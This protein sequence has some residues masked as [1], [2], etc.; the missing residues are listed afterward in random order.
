VPDYDVV[1]AGLGPVG[2]VLA[3]RLTA[4]GM[5]VLV[6]EKETAVFALPRAIAADDEVQEI[7][8]RCG[9]GLVEPML[10]DQ[11]VRFVCRDREIGTIR[12]PRSASGFCGL[13]FFHQPTLEASLRAMLT[14]EATKRWPGLAVAA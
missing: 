10:H 3:L 14:C 11:A 4:A 1:I 8:A 13:A 5:S 9:P 12:F 6:V 2:A 7:L